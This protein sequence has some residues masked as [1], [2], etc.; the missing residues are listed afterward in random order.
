MEERNK[1]EAAAAWERFNNS[2]IPMAEDSKQ[3]QQRET[4][5]LRTV[6]VFAVCFIMAGTMNIPINGETLWNVVVVQTS[7]YFGFFAETSGD[8]VVL[9]VEVTE[10]MMEAQKPTWIPERFEFV[11]RVVTEMDEMTSYHWI[12]EGDDGEEL[13]INVMY[14]KTAISTRLPYNGQ[15]VIVKNKQIDGQMYYLLKRAE[16]QY[17]MW[18]YNNYDCTIVGDVS[19]DEILQ[20]VQSISKG[21]M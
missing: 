17:C 13:V 12:Y 10:E 11:E 14:L 21:R 18:Q 16:R 1:R 15:E 19:E 7:E 2:Y 4:K 6:A 8:K 3:E 20:M 5:W 9:D